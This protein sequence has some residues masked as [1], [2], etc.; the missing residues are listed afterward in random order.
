MVMMHS[1]VLKRAAPAMEKL[2][3]MSSYTEYFNRM[4]K[5]VVLEKVLVKAFAYRKLQSAIDGLESIYEYASEVQESR[6][7]ELEKKM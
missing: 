6:D 3:T 1:A 7:V 2:I 4:Q 5:M